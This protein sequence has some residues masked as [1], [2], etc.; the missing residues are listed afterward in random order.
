MQ[1]S[2]EKCFGAGEP[3]GMFTEDAFLKTAATLK[4]LSPDMKVLFYWHSTVEIASP[5]SKPCYAAGQ[6]FVQHPEW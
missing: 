5:G 6:E 3:G 4:A 1:V 2:L